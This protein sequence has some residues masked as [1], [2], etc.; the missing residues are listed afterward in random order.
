M[1]GTR[2]DLLAAAFLDA[3][4]LPAA[5]GLRLEELR[6]GVLLLVES[7]LDDLGAEPRLLDAEQVR[8]LLLERVARKLGR[9]DPL[10]P[11]IPDLARAFF[12]WLAETELVPNSFEIDLALSTID[13]PFL[14]AARAV[15]PEERI[16]GETRTLE[17]RGLKLGRNDPCPCG[18]GRKFKRCCMR[19]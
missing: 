13:E 2:A 7:A 8:A 5:A 17:N 1:A 6:R 16:A 9:S 4:R 11:V 14:E 15:R 3:P 12:A 18:S 19:S 10:A